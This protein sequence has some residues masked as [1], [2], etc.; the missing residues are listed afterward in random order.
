MNLASFDVLVVGAGIAGSSLVLQLRALRPDITIAVIDKAE[1]PREKVCGCCLNHRAIHALESLPGFAGYVPTGHPLEAF[2][3]FTSGAPAVSVT[4]PRSIAISR[5]LLDNALLFAIRR[6]NVQSFA[7]TQALRT[8]T[9]NDLRYIEVRRG[10]RTETLS[11]SLVIA[12]DGLGGPFAR[13]AGLAKPVSAPR[14]IGASVIL[15][16]GAFSR[17]QDRAISMFHGREGYA[18]IVRLEDRRWN[19]AACLRVDRLDGRSPTN[20]LRELLKT[21]GIELP[22]ETQVSVTPPLHR[23]VRRPWK[24][25][26]LLAGDAAGYHEPFT[27][28]GMAW[29]LEAAGALAPLAACGWSIRMAR[30]WEKTWRRQQGKRTVLRS[31]AAVLDHERLTQAVA[32]VAHI[33]P[34]APNLTVRELNRT[35]RHV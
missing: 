19:V 30:M 3:F 10:G 34:A 28:E 21:H 26:L 6:T 33:L 24:N 25:R 16:S 29:A 35:S 32:Q 2:K 27:G 8:W 20:A 7:G 31:L 23:K 9:D 11:A 14:K 17:L 1:F 18:G 22:A 4:L 13:W 5:G 15:E 12:C